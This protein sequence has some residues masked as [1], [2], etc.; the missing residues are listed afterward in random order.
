MNN[1]EMELT[2]LSEEEV[3]GDKDGNGKLEVLK[4]YGTI[5]AV[6]DLVILTGGYI[7]DRYNYH[8]PE[9]DTLKGRAGWCYTRC[10][11]G[12]GNIRG[13]FSDGSRCYGLRRYLRN[14]AIRPVLKLSPDIF[15]KITA[16]RYKGFNGTEEVLFGEY[17]QYVPDKNIQNFLEMQ[18]RKHNLKKTD[19]T[20]TFDRTGSFDFEQS[21]EKIT[22][23]EYEYNNQ[24]YIRIQNNSY[25]KFELSNGKKYRNGNYV[26]IKVSPV[27]WLIDDKTKTLVA[28]RGLVSGIRFHTKDY[29]YNGN[30]Y[31]TEMKEYLDKYMIHD[32][33]QNVDLT[34]ILSNNT[35]V[36]NI[37]SNQYKLQYLLHELNKMES[38]IKHLI[39]EYQKIDPKYIDEI[40]NSYLNALNNLD[41]TNIIK[42]KLTYK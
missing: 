1:A 16:N 24:K 40:Y 14:G 8:D 38:K 29:K 12:N 22:Y 32:L 3:F 23:N 10:S 26:W 4:K 15:N 20:Y 18:Y 28:K 33:F 13:V 9:D 25:S 2:L 30:F 7:D 6:T 11:D 36:D 39:E 27:E 35:Q 41:N 34:N 17:T 19:S 42:K 21:F 37:T 31:T 5:S